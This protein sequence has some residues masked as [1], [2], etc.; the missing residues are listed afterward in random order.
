MQ[1]LTSPQHTVTSGSDGSSKLDKSLL[2]NSVSTNGTGGETLRDG[3]MLCHIE[4]IVVMKF[5]VVY[6]VHD[7]KSNVIVTIF[8]AFQ[9]QR[10]IIHWQ[11]C[12]MGYHMVYIL[13][14][15]SSAVE[16]SILTGRVFCEETF[17]L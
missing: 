9:V 4:T 10:S 16:L 14:L 12:F 15:I 6:Q 2:T 17:I 13:Y 8:I 3:T 5:S 7:A 11:T 1:E